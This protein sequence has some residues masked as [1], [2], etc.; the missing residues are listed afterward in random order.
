MEITKL[1][2]LLELRDYYD[3]KLGLHATAYTHTDSKP[4]HEVHFS[5]NKQRLAI[6]DELIIEAEG[7]DEA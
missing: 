4:G 3:F 1:G 5:E 2:L 6:V 7:T